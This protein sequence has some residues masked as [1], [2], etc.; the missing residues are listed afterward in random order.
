L[1]QL[2][3]IFD[4]MAETS[5]SPTLL[6]T[7]KSARSSFRRT[8]RLFPHLV[9]DVED[10]SPGLASLRSLSAS[11]KIKKQVPSKF[12]QEMPTARRS[13]EFDEN[14]SPN[15]WK[16][17]PI[18]TSTFYGSSS[19]VPR[20]LSS[21]F[22]EKMNLKTPPKEK[23]TTEKKKKTSL[24]S[25][26]KSATKFGREAGGNKG[27]SHA[28]QKPKIKKPEKQKSSKSGTESAS[29]DLEDFEKITATKI[30][31]MKTP[32]LNSLIKQVMTTPDTGKIS[33]AN[34]KSVGFE[35]KNGQMTFAYRRRSPRKTVSPYFNKTRTPSADPKTPKRLFTPSAKNDMIVDYELTPEKAGGRRSGRQN[36]PS[37]VKFHREADDHDDLDESNDNQVTGILENL[38][39]SQDNC[40]TV[41][42]DELARVA[43]ET[44]RQVF[45]KQ[46]LDLEIGDILAHI[47]TPTKDEKEENRNHERGGTENL[48]LALDD[49]DSNDGVGTP[50]TFAIFDKSKPKTTGTRRSPRKS[51]GQQFQSNPKENNVKNTNKKSL[52]KNQMIIDAGQ[53]LEE[54]KTCIDCSFVYNPGNKQDDDEHNKN[55]FIAQ[56]GINFSGWKN[57]H[58]VGEFQTENGRI[59]VVRPKDR[60]S[61]W[62]KVK[63]VIEVVDKQL[64]INSGES[65][66]ENLRKKDETQAYMYINSNKI[67]GLLLAETINENDSISK[68]I[69]GNEDQ[70]VLEELPKGSPAVLA[71][72]SRIWTAMNFRRQGLATKMVKAME[73]NFFGMGCILEK[74]QDYAFSHT[75]PDG[76]TF[77]SKHTGGFF[78][79]YKPKF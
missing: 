29:S 44:T 79:T 32:K 13:A 69:K 72:I 23:K 51:L 70:W 41:T 66:S 36:L 4:K 62:A 25:K 43:A 17:S 59:I 15:N 38:D 22:T 78:L 75:T 45:Q 52:D 65:S 48:Q 49:D 54:A 39:M 33:M 64:G 37:P 53:K 74:G 16:K 7:P 30:K 56:E 11:P 77:A 5:P 21:S 6:R 68:A 34:D 3:S 71:G 47:K 31:P 14:K 28:I 57:E 46:Q 42:D 24:G 63:D 10:S 1:L 19:Y 20:Y 27:V 61:H 18:K 73:T 50:K 26:S 2:E 40:V 76:S 35:I 60:S 8:R 55:H 12:R 67:V 58:V 9:D